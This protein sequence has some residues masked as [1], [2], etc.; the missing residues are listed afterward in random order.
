MKKIVI[1]SICIALVMLI[2][3]CMLNTVS[4]AEPV[5]TKKVILG[6][7]HY[8][9]DK[10]FYNPDDEGKPIKILYYLVFDGK[11]KNG[12][13]KTS[14]VFREFNGKIGDTINSTENLDSI[15]DYAGET[16][17]DCDIHTIGLP[18]YNKNYL[19][20]CAIGNSHDEI[21]LQFLQN[22]NTNTT[23]K[24]AQGSKILDIDKND[25]PIRFTIAKKQDGKEIYP[26][27]NKKRAR[28]VER[29]MNFKEGIMPV[30]DDDESNDESFKRAID[31]SMLEMFNPYSGK[32][33]SF[34]L[35]AEF[36]GPKK[37]DLEKRY[38]LSMKGD[39]I[40]GW[41]LTLK[42]KPEAKQEIKPIPKTGDSSKVNMYMAF[43]AISAFAFVL[44]VLKRKATK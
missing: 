18:I 2:G 39:D 17:T 12:E 30:W 42:S 33:I 10:G 1:R 11:D 25:L 14:Y 20:A 40:K 41:T 36:A 43:V 16:Y 22:M 29:T 44:V 35:R 28:V 38:E 4:F 9:M 23:A 34:E 8:D 5:K 27:V 31:G 24:L 32:T 15:K 13:K 6:W 26:F 37:A 21:S 7:H 3:I 19:Y